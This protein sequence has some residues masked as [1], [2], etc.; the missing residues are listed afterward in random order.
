MSFD[1]NDTLTKSVYD[2]SEYGETLMVPL[3]QDSALTL[4]TITPSTSTFDQSNITSTVFPVEDINQIISNIDEISIAHEGDDTAFNRIYQWQPEGY[5]VVY[6]L[7]L[8]GAFGLNVSVDTSGSWN[9]DSV[10]LVVTSHLPDGTLERTI[11]DK[12]VSSSLSA[13]TDVGT[14]I[15][16][17]DINHSIPFEVKA[18]HPIRIQIIVGTT[19]GVGTSQVGIIPLFCFNSEAT[20]KVFTT[21]IFKMHI[22]PSL[23]NA[24]P[25]IRNTTPSSEL[26]YGGVTVGGV[27]RG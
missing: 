21:S 3:V 16:L 26:D 7:N 18:D 6:K 2:S 24:Y 25:V 15:F 19:L 23:D 17:V 9:L 22:H 12:T 14:Q 10:R 8:F 4:Q 20:N 27:V 11:I 1:N 5:G 13:L